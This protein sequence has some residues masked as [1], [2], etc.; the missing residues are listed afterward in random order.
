MS[1]FED[2]Q[3]SFAQ[4][5][6]DRREFIIRSSAMGL[7]FA[8]PA[9][10]VAEQARADAPKRGGHMRVATVQGST[11]DKLDPTQLTSGFTNFTFYST[12]SQLTEVAPDGN[13]IP[14]LAESYEPIDNNPAKWLFTLRK[15][16]EFHN[17]KTVTADDVI[18]SITRHTGKD[19][20]SA[21]K[22][23][24]EQI[25]TMS[26]DGDDKVI[27]H[28]KS[29]SVDWPFVLSASAL[30]ILP[31]KD[32]KVTEFDKGSGAY[33]IEDFR[34]G[35]SIKLK[36]NPN[37]FMPNAGYADTAELLVI[38]D[39]T[40][41]QNALVTGSVDII[42]DVEAKTAHLLAK[43]PGV[44]VSDVTSTQHYTFPMRTD[45]A[46][47]DNLDVRLAL[48]Y[49]IDREKVLETILRGRGAL[50]NDHPISPANRYFASDLE[51]RAYDPEK[52]KFHLKK[53]GME[54]LKVELTASDGLYSGA[55][56]T[57]VLFAEHAKKAGIEI[58]P[59]RAPDDGY[60]SDVWLKH[61]WCASYWSGRPTEDWM[62]TQG[63][64]ADSNWNE[65]YWKNPRFND[66]LKQ[67]RAE[68]DDSKRREMY[69]ELQMLV[70]DDGGS[71][72]HLFANHISAHSD[73]VGQPAKIAGNWEF[74]GY[75][76]I[77]RWW[78]KG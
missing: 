5:R 9:G 33:M 70:R 41:R 63:Y 75:K 23:F 15:G 34:P 60:W 47:F 30:S 61:P 54:N 78:M 13:L 8:V 55:V 2:L 51:Q 49:A 25:E 14:L 45:L 7:L 17:G 43:S 4:G 36:R 50:G 42:G 56:D 71:V 35:I 22:S 38:A 65:T 21:M 27:F 11:T 24:V 73:K 69:R 29:P 3:R 10:L 46:P 28:L 74:D 57:V 19:S 67:A 18:A 6:I 37:H 68:L 39:S 16:V 32:G 44:T 66:V 26:K 62:F 53:A 64:A 77:E 1:K 59:K 58:T 52:A 40:A 72:I 76:M 12:M 31:S 48:K 20:A